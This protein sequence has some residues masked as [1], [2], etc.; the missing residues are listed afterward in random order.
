[1]EN[2]KIKFSKQANKDAKKLYS[3]GLHE[4]AETIFRILES[5]PFQNPPSYEKLLGNLKGLY[6]RRINLQHR[7]IYQVNEET[8]IVKVIRMWTHYE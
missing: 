4:K 3:A 8:K 2:W 7:L 1:M 5:N 6:S